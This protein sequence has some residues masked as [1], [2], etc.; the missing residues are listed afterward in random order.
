MAP[1]L[2]SPAAIDDQ[3][4]PTRIK[5]DAPPKKGS[6]SF[7]KKRN[8]KLLLLRRAAGTNGQIGAALDR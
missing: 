5:T 2:E 3:R 6:I 4:M 1:R 7:L 8:K